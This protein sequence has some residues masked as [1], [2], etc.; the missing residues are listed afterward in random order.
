M[1]FKKRAKQKRDWYF[2]AEAAG[3]LGVKVVTVYRWI[4]CGALTCDTKEA[5]LR[6]P[7]AAVERVIAA[8]KV[9][10]GGG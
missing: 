2:P 6:I 5:Y 8:Q 9:V 1:L 4:G 7:C 10:V 3:V